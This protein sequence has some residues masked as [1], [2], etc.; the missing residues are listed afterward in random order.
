MCHQ[1]ILA[2]NLMLS[3]TLPKFL[4][5]MVWKTRSKNF[6][7]N[8]PDGLVVFWDIMLKLTLFC[9]N[10]GK[11]KKTNPPNHSFAAWKIYTL[12]EIYIYTTVK[13]LYKFVLNTI[14]FQVKSSNLLILNIVF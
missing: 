8:C 2:Y 11:L 3:I 7:A 13:R 6:E 10:V 9:E 4:K 14:I 1:I 5:S 12:T